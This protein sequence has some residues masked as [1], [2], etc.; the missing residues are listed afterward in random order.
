MKFSALEGWMAGTDC[1]VVGCG[2]SSGLAT[3]CR[4]EGGLPETHFERYD[5]AR[6]YW[7]KHRWTIACNRSVTFAS[8]DFALCVEP[9][10][11]DD[12][13]AIIREAAPLITFGHHD[14][15]CPRK[16]VFDRDV[17]K[18]LPAPNPTKRLALGQSSFWAAAVALWLGFETVGLIGVDITPDRFPEQWMPGIEEAWGRLH[19]TAGIMGRK[20]VNLNPDTHLKAV[21]VGTWEEV[22][23]K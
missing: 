8:P 16:V 19:E 12:I 7:N 21:P 5:T 10:R 23:T 9:P 17:A 20:M 6:S 18:W 15:G 3:E 13:W 14:K 2:P 11:D 1:A 22:R 4:P